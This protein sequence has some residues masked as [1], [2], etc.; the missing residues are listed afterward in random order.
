MLLG[1][2]NELQVLSHVVEGYSHLMLREMDEADTLR[3]APVALLATA[4][5]LHEMTGHLRTLA[6]GIPPGTAATDHLEE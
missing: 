5:R 2:A 4:E 1:F 6:G 3:R